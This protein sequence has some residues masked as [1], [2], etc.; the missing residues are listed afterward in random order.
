MTGPKLYPDSEL[1]EI[2]E[3]AYKI[4]GSYPADRVSYALSA[5]IISALCIARTYKT[6]K[7]S[8]SESK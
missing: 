7:Q 1:I 5:A 6:D 8:T 3:R 4:T 2:L